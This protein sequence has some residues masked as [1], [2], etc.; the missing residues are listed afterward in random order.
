MFHLPTLYRVIAEPPYLVN[1]DVAESQLSTN[2]A[3]ADIVFFHGLDGSYDLTWQAAGPES[4]WP[5]WLA[6]DLPDFAVWSMSYVAR[7]SEWQGATLPI[8]EQATNLLA[9]MR[10]RDIGRRPICLVGHS[11]GGLMIKQL[12]RTGE[13]RKREFPDIVANVKRIAFIATPHTGTDVVRWAKNMRAI[14]RPTVLVENLDSDNEGLRKLNSWYRTWASNNETA[15]LALCETEP[16]IFHRFIKKL[17]VPPLSADPEL[18]NVS[19]IRL[20]NTDHKDICKPLARTAETYRYFLEFTQALRAATASRNRDPAKSSHPR[21]SRFSVESA[22]APDVGTTR[23]YDALV[24]HRRVFEGSGWRSTLSRLYPSFRLVEFGNS[25]FPIW[26]APALP[27]EWTVINASLNHLDDANPVD[28]VHYPDSFDPLGK[29]EH[30]RRVSNLSRWNFNGATYALDRIRRPEE[31]RIRIDARR[32]TYFWSV[33]TS[34]LLDREFMLAQAEAPERDL[35][36][37]VLPMRRRLHDIAGGENV[38]FD[39]RGRSS[40]L[41]IA[42]SMIFCEPDGTYSALLS[43]RSE[44]VATHQRLEHVAPAGILAPTTQRQLDGRTPISSRAERRTA[45]S[46]EFSVEES[47]LREYAEE[48]F[49]YAD[50]EQDTGDPTQAMRDS[51]PIHGLLQAIN[52][53]IVVLRYCGVSVPLLTLRPEICVLMLVRDLSWWEQE[54]ERAAATDHRFQLNWEYET[55]YRGRDAMKLKFDSNLVPSDD[56]KVHPANM[57]PHAAASLY[58]ATN[59]ARNILF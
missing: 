32:G 9:E 4:F 6:S 17:V 26:A 54:L 8:L 59:V 34:E 28:F 52:S 56:P 36:L 19:L 20:E 42:V 46:K 49:G 50:F 41:S 11:L 38:I 2:E 29:A 12:L 39:G 14:F 51:P 13:E 31:G 35:T 48:L 37:D 10:N 3:V 23:P 53:G 40:A 44:K 15:T 16:I 33:A 25:Y 47:L 1:Q 22:T 7:L 24:A 45:W 18:P 30:D 27:E 43:P 21:D 55:T 57:V 58:L 5:S